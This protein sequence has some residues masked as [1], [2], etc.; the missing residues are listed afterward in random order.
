LWGYANDVSL[1]SS[2]PRWLQR[3]IDC[4]RACCSE[5][6]LIVNPTKCKVV[7]FG[8]AKAWSRKRDWTLQAPGGGHTPLAVSEYFKYLGVK[9]H[10][11]KCIRAAARHR[12]SRMVA[13]QSGVSR[14]LKALRIPQAP[15]VVS[16]M[17]AAVTAVAGSYGCEVWS[18]HFQGGWCLLDRLCKLQSY[19]ATVYKQSLGV[20][21]SA[22][23]LLTFFEMGQ[24]PMLVQW[25]ARTLRYWNKLA[26]LAQQGAS[27]LRSGFLANVASG[28]ACGRAYTWAAELHAAL[29]F[30]CPEQVWTPHML[31]GLPI[32]V[33]P[34]VGAACRA[35]CSLLS[36]HTSSPAADLCPKRHACKYNSHMLR[37]GGEDGHAE[38][39][40]PAYLHAFVPP[41]HKRALARLRLSKAPIQTNMQLD[42]AYTRRWCTRGCDVA[43]DSEHH[44]LF[45]FPARADVRVNPKPC[46]LP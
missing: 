4:F 20:P 25:L 10:G 41:A 2:T 6:G 24:Y 29:Q 31:Q 43:T 17:F 26:E 16:G 34:V 32:E 38:L 46:G 30:V 12:L 5:E 3:L 1:C 14:R 33:K 13:A 37:D 23:S 44:L 8:G 42:V 27:L 18:I 39:P 28:L 35:L 40:V 7:V 15:C 45:E 36:A 9:L 11:R 22:A 19:Q 21:R